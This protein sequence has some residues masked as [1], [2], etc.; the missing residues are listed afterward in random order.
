M[1]L[2]DYTNLLLEEMTT[3]LNAQTRKEGK[4]KAAK[5]KKG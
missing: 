5:A 2:K 4:R 3:T 1:P